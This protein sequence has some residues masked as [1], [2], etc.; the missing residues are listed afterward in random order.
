MIQHYFK[1]NKASLSTFMIINHDS[2]PL[3]LCNHHSEALFLS[4]NILDKRCIDTPTHTSLAFLGF[5]IQNVLSAEKDTKKDIFRFFFPEK[6]SAE[7]Y[8]FLKFHFADQE[9]INKLQAEVEACPSSKSMI[10]RL[11]GWVLTFGF[12][13]IK[14]N[15]KY[16]GNKDSTKPLNQAMRCVFFNPF[17]LL[18]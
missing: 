2:S 5:T 15:G 10:S 11:V 14:W 16:Y 6:T 13:R 12:S 17:L 3:W 9:D 18:L 1:H 4:S 8:V 7:T